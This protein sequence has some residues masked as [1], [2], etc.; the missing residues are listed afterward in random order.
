MYPS[1]G[2]TIRA[3]LNTVV[4]EAALADTF[5]IGTQ[6]MPEFG[7]D[8]KSG[9]YAKLTKQLSELMNDGNTIRE[10]NGAY[11]R[12]NRAWTNDTYDCTDRGLEE[13]IDDTDM[14]DVGR[15]FDLEANSAKIVLRNMRLSHEIRVKDAIFSTTNFGSATN[16]NVA[17]TEALIATMN[18][19]LDVLAAIEAVN[20]NGEEADTI[21]MSP[22]VFNR[23]KRSTL[24]QNWLRGSQPQAVT[25]NTTPSAMAASFAENGIKQVLVGRARYNSAKKGQAYSASRVWSDTYVWVG[26]VKGGDFM[27]GGAGR[28]L[29]WNKEGG[30]FVTETYRDEQKRSNIV[31]VR[32][33]TAEKVVNAA[34]GTLIATQ[35]S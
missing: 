34:A 5:Y 24:M 9:T 20:D 27:N 1:S 23:V 35:Y 15:F 11:G 21:V 4:E 16:S 29:V 8:A 25:L 2:A 19:P 31:R 10:R 14:K 13:A 32:Q 17:Y 22:N 33:N 6:L 28:T 30:L 3:D 18:F 12:I 26:S 7:V